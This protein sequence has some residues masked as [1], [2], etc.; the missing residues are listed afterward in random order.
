MAQI[1]RDN[2]VGDDPGAV[3]LGLLAHFE[4]ELRTDDAAGEAG[5]VLDFRGQVELAQ[6]KHAAQ[7]VLFGDRAFV[8]QRLQVRPRRINSGSPPG[9]PGTDDD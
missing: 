6:G 4:H 9:R 8:D 2:V 3:T 1:D 5:E 7:A